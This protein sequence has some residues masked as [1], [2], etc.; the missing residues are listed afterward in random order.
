MTPLV[1]FKSLS[2]EFAMRPE[3]LFLILTVANFLL[4]YGPWGEK[5]SFSIGLLGI[6]LPLILALAGSGK[7]RVQDPA[8]KKELFIPPATLWFFA[9]FLILSFHFYRWI[10]YL[11]FPLYD[12]LINA[13]C[14]L[15][16]EKH[17]FWHLFFYSTQLP[18]FYIW[19]LALDFRILGPSFFSLW[20]L[21]ALLSLAGTAIFYFLLRRLFSKS[22]AFLGFVFMGVDFWPVFIG[23]FSHQAGLMVLWE[24]VALSGLTWLALDRSGKINK[25]GLAGLGLWTGL[26]FYTYFGWPLVALLISGTVWIVIFRIFRPR[27]PWIIALLFTT[28]LVVAVFPQILAYLKGDYGAYLS[29][30]WALRPNSSASQLWNPSISVDYF[31]TFFWK[32]WSQTFAYNPAWGGFLNPIA[33]GFFM[34][35]CVE[36]FRNR[37]SW[38]SRWCAFAFLVLFVPI[39]FV[40]NTNWFHVSALM[41]VFLAI[42]VVGFQTLWIWTPQKKLQVTWIVLLMVSMALDGMNLE[43]TSRFAR[44]NYPSPDLVRADQIVEKIHREQ[45]PGWVIADF[46]LKPWTPYL[47]F[48]TST[49]GS[50]TQ[51]PQWVAVLANVNYQPFLKRRFPESRAY[52]VSENLT[53]ADGGLMLW[54]LPLSAKLLP[55]IGKWEQASQS[56]SPLFDQI[57][58]VDPGHTYG[59]MAETLKAIAPQ[60]LGDPFLQSIDGELQSQLEFKQALWIEGRRKNKIDGLEILDQSLVPSSLDPQAFQASIQDLE[61]SIREGYPAAHLFYQWGILESISGNTREARRAFLRA[62]ESPLDFTQAEI[63]LKTSPFLR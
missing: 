5:I 38:F 22:A 28:P 19:L 57:L 60:F 1:F 16:I 18:P 48:D 35:G 36:L 61:Q 44:Q 26:G 59:E 53:E 45:G 20:L 12:E 49:L 14:A 41:P 7:T 37:S 54:V 43:K 55:E 29:S 46:A 47:R 30:L 62:K 6:I 11:D 58:Q 3:I 33:T 34:T 32:G 23:H 13:F 17:G 56:L 39:L 31:T 8:W 10:T 21:P 27:S 9:G 2:K 50:Q 25:L 51:T 4:A 42:M 52:R 15:G 24:I 63:I 40:N